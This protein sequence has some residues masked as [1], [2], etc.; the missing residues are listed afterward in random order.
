[1]SKNQKQEIIKRIKQVQPRRTFRNNLAQSHFD[2]EKLDEQTLKKRAEQ[3]SMEEF[4][5]IWKLLIV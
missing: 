3:L 4:L 1:M 2:I 5:H